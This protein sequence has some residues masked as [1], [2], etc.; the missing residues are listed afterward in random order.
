MYGEYYLNDQI[1]SYASDSYINEK[2]K[3]LD[4]TLNT[5]FSNG[6]TVNAKS[7]CTYN[8]R[9]LPIKC[10]AVVKNSKNGVIEEMKYVGET[11]AV[12]Y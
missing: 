9:K 8:Q 4:Y 5:V 2:D 7:S 3:P 10:V 1:S 12:F 6:Y 11:E